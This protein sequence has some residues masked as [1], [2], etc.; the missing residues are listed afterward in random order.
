LTLHYLDENPAGRRTVLLL[1]GLGVNSSSWL[2]Q[3]EVLVV[4]GYRVLAPDLRGFGRSTYPGR[5]SLAEM[6]QDAAA[7][8]RA[9]ASGPVDVAGI[10]MGGA[11]ALHLALD[12]PSLVRS[13]VL[14]NTSGRLRPHHLGGWLSYALRYLALRTIGMY[15]QARLVCR[16]TFPYPYQ[17]ELRRLLF[18]QIMQS[19]R[20]GYRL[21]LWEM[22]CLN[23]LPRLGQIQ[24]PTLIVTGAE[25][26]TIRPENQRTLVEAIAGAQQVIIPRGG[27]A[28]TVEHIEEF[29]RA[30]LGF[31]EQSEA[32]AE[33]SAVRT[34]AGPT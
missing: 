1:H 16:H 22:G 10:S 30:L 9:V 14:V 6:A 12:H 33:V 20:H 24:A 8:L 29:N 19:N 21:S 5:T 32:A 26:R 15:A 28:V 7:L 3:M 4:A 18:E 31:L 2:P 23:L 17:A 27:H 25:D 34:S 11:V 13:Q